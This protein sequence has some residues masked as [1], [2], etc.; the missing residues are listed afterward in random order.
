MRSRRRQR[1]LRQRLFWWFGGAIVV[2]TVV[3]AL[4]FRAL[5]PE[6]S[7]TRHVAGLRA[8]TVSQLADVWDDD[9]AR[10]RLTR[11]LAEHLQIGVR[12]EDPTG[13]R[14]SEAG[15]ACRSPRYTLDVEQDGRRYGRASVCFTGARSAMAPAAFAAALV[16]AAVVLWALAGRV[17]RRIAL[18][19]SELGRVAQEIGKGNLSS[20][21]RLRRDA[22]GEIGELAEAIDDMAVRIE[23]QLVAQKELLAA[24]SHEIRTPLTRLRVLLELLRERGTTPETLASLEEEVRE[25]DDLVGDLLASSRLDFQGAAPIELS[26]RDLAL[27]ALERAGVEAERLQD[28]TSGAH[29]LADP[30]LLGRALANLLDNARRHGGAV[31]LMAVRPRGD[32][33]AFEVEDSGPG[34]AA[35]VLPRA[36][37][38][39]HAGDGPGERAGALGLGLSLVRR[40]AEAHG[41]QAR[42]ENLPGGGARVGFDV[43]GGKTAPHP[44][45]A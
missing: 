29:V 13:A 37:E 23:R 34:F 43:P 15:G 40:I 14:L 2:T 26:A 28:E 20:R 45:R 11:S 38:P 17:A 42:A 8:F 41:G 25:I 10:E 35:D 30:T 7:W 9:D 3:V 18:P 24:V 12:L 1:R 22:P 32:R 21:A 39:F 5:R 31:E 4:V 27:R 19:L 6:Q 16:A 36:F 33:V 44:S